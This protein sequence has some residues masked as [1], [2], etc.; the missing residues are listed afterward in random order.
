MSDD[1]SPETRPEAQTSVP[2]Y[3][4]K[5]TISVRFGC[6]GGDL[7]TQP[8]IFLMPD[9]DHCA[10]PGGGKQYALFFPV[11]EDTACVGV[12]MS[13]PESGFE[14]PFHSRYPISS[15][16][17]FIGH[18]SRSKSSGRATMA[19]DCLRSPFLR[20]KEKVKTRSHTVLFW[21][22]G[23]NSVA[24]LPTTQDQASF[25]RELAPNPRTPRCLRTRVRTALGDGVSD[26]WI[27]ACRTADIWRTR[28][29]WYG[30]T[31]QGP[32]RWH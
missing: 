17:R 23:R 19:G 5:G 22:R 13:D 12:P 26:R 3:K 11:D 18:W 8:K 10:S 29:G 9:T 30:W 27:G 32:R 16:Q 1:S 14:F 6:A 15:Q 20:R 21:G 24:R 28:L 2:T 4:A 7:S 25:L 31:G